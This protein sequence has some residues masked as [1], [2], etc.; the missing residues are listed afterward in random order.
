MK[1]SINEKTVPWR[2]NDV[3]RDPNKWNG[4]VGDMCIRLDTMGDFIFWISQSIMPSFRMMLDLILGLIQKINK[5]TLELAS[6]LVWCWSLLLDFTWNIRPN[7]SIMLKLMWTIQH[8]EEL[9]QC[10]QIG[11]FACSLVFCCS[12]NPNLLYLYDQTKQTTTDVRAQ[13]QPIW[14]AGCARL[15]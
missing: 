3:Y 12:F 11:R 10:I 4:R 9:S 7:V 15:I 6:F 1:D 8:H 2:P 14:L 13:L 5:V